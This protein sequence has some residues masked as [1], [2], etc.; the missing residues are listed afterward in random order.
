LKL[1]R[2]LES[3]HQLCHTERSE[4]SKT[5]DFSAMP[6]NKVSLE[7]DR[8]SE[9]LTIWRRFWKNYKARAI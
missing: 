6:Q 5:A 7:N 8:G 1:A 9:N 4:V 2:I 3:S